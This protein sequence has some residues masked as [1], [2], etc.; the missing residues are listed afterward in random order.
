MLDTRISIV[1][2]LGYEYDPKEPERTQ[3]IMANPNIPPRRLW[4]L[5]ILSDTAIYDSP[6]EELVFVKTTGLDPGAFDRYCVFDITY[7]VYRVHIE[8]NFLDTREP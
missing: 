1:Y 6:E 2:P 8:A 3:S 5:P 4:S 7:G